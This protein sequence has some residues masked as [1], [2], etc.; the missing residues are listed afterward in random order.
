MIAYQT[1]TIHRT[2]RE[3]YRCLLKCDAEL[4]LP[5]DHE[6]IC[7]YY[8][9]MAESCLRWAEAAEGERLREAYLALEDHLLQARVGVAQYRLRC[10]PIWQ[11]SG[12]VSYLCRSVMRIGETETRRVMSQ[13]WNLEEQTL[14]PMSRIV[15]QFSGKTT[16]KRIPFRPDGVYPTEGEL[17]FYRNGNAAEEGAEFRVPRA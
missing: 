7:A 14:L 13:V 6:R 5:Q 3:G 4:I 10:E 16:P 1:E 9:R 2:T 8:R 15:K 17:V 12:Y 11:E